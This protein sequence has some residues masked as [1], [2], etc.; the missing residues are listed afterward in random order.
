MTRKPHPVL[1][2]LGVVLAL[3]VVSILV[4]RVLPEG[5]RGRRLLNALNT[6][7]TMSARVLVMLGADPN[8]Q[9]G[10]GTAMHYAAANGDVDLMRFLALQG[11]DV[12]APGEQ[13]VT[14][15][16]LARLHGHAG[17]ERFLLARGANPKTP[18]PPRILSP[19]T[20][21]PLTSAPSATPPINAQ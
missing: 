7:H 19:L 13:G 9:T 10:H 18:A 14:P 2:A 1:I 16:Y 12:D 4:F 21:A 5:Y 11:A 6:G 15:L 3:C 17:A 8:F 20:S